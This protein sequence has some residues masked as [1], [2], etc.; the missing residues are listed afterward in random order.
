MSYSAVGTMYATAGFG[1]TDGG[2]PPA[3]INVRTL[4]QV[5]IRKGFNVGP[6]GADGKWGDRTISAISSALGV[7]AGYEFQAE[8]LATTVSAPESLWR[9][10]NE[11]PDRPVGTGTGPS[12]E[13]SRE[14]PAVTTTTPTTTT[15]EDAPVDDPGSGFVMPDW[16][17][18]AIGGA[19]LLGVGGFFLWKGRGRRPAAVAA[20]RRRRRRSSRRSRR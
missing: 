18:Y 2:L 11:M 10:L 6:A 14:A 13:R 15:P 17:P 12:G 9:R 16:A 7:A 8:R 1:V 3:I 5:L 4:Q 19:A 20:N